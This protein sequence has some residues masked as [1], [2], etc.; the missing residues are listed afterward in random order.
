MRLLGGEHGKF[1]ASPRGVHKGAVLPFLEKFPD[2]V[3]TSVSQVELASE[4]YG[5]TFSYYYLVVVLSK[6]GGNRPA[7]RVAT[8]LAERSFP[9]R[10][11]AELE[12][13]PA[14][15]REAGGGSSGDTSTG[16]WRTGMVSLLTAIFHRTGSGSGNLKLNFKSA[17]RAHC[18]AAVCQ[19]SH[20]GGGSR[21][22]YCGPVAPCATL[23]LPPKP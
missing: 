11:C 19:A 13:L 3:C 22:L 21:R 20:G 15:R 16:S 18:E 23:S 5:P 6:I 4:W 7:A 12:A 8:L 14:L 17:T 2:S 9:H 10:V 1:P